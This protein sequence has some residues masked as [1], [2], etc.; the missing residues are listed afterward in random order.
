M[1]PKTKI[2]VLSL[3]LIFLLSICGWFF[4]RY[5][6]RFRSPITIA[7]HAPMTLVRRVLAYNITVVKAPD[8]LP[9][10][11]N[12]KYLCIK[13]GSQCRTALEIQHLENGTEQCDRMNV[14]DNH[15][16]DFGFMQI[17][18]V[19]LNSTVKVADLI[20]CKKNID[21]AYALYQKQGWGIWS[22][23]KLIK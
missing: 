9:L 14:N 8:P 23:Y 21:I 20:D 16:V 12:E 15:T 19:H 6:L 5:E 18:S 4:G 22:S 13:F 2:L 17:N 11:D 7:I 10:N 3:S 1:Q